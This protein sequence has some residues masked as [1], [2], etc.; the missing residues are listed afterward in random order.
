MMMYGEPA[1]TTFVDEPFMPDAESM[2]GYQEQFVDDLKG[3]I[4]SEI[5][6]YSEGTAADVTANLMMN[7]RADSAMFIME[8]MMEDSP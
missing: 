5:I 2:M 8:I 7:S 3:E 4:F 6:N 1:E